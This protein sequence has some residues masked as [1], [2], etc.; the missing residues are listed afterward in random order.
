M[1]IKDEVHAVKRKREISRVPTKTR[2]ETIKPQLIPIAKRAKS[3]NRMQ[4]SE[5][6]ARLISLF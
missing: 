6:P 5:F 1:Q 3:K 4:I 2:E